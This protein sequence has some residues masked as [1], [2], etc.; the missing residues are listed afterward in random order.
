MYIFCFT[1]NF[2]SISEENLGVI[3]SI[4]PATPIVRKMN[5]SLLILFGSQTG[6]A[7]AIAEQIGRE[8]KRFHFEPKVQARTTKSFGLRNSSQSWISYHYGNGVY[9]REENLS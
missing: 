9:L 6:T 8:V 7:Q 4:V 2:F 1:L 3:Q 5:R